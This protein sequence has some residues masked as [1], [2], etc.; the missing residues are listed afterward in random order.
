M[1]S[2]MTFRLAFGS[3]GNALRAAGFEPIKVIPFGARKGRKNKKGVARIKSIH[4][5][6][7]IFLPTHPMAM[8]NGYVR[9]H[10]MVAYDAGLLI[11]PTMEVHHRNGIKTD[12]RIEN[13]EIMTK[14]K[15]TSLTWKGVKG[16]NGRKKR[17][18]I[19]NIYESPE[20]LK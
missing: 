12:N 2:D 9:E 11:D 8:K 18:I 4:G 3:W 13:L 10:R 15:H 16:K 19:G 7:H 17:E 20:L 6:I 14:A 5:Y 1:P